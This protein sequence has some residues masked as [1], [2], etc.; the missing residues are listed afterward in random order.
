LEFHGE[1]LSASIDSGPDCR[2]KI[3]VSQLA[4]NKGDNE[5]DIISELDP[6]RPSAAD[7]RLLSY[8]FPAVEV[9]EF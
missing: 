4:L 2:E 6:G 3:E 9:D 1:P 8:F 7:P 5:V